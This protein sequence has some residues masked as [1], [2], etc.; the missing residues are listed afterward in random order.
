[1][2]GFM[3]KSEDNLAP[4]RKTDEWKDQQA[5]ESEHKLEN[6]HE[7]AP[8]LMLTLILNPQRRLS[9][10]VEILSIQ[11]SLSLELS[12]DPIAKTEDSLPP[13]IKT[14]VCEEHQEQKFESRRVK[15]KEKHMYEQFMK[16]RSLIN[17]IPDL[18]PTEKSRFS[19]KSLST[20]TS[21]NPG[22]SNE[23]RSD[24]EDN[25]PV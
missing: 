16:R 10:S 9:F 3:W 13:K 11:T 4:E 1:M 7:G 24:S 23:L 5:A 8:S 22:L 19:D 14:T 2:T 25:L 12:A 6:K 21:D 15:V 17:A 18:D 20:E